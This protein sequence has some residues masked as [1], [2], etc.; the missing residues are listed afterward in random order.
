MAQVAYALMMLIV[1][2]VVARLRDRSLNSNQH[3]FRYFKRYALHQPAGLTMACTFACALLAFILLNPGWEMTYNAEPLNLRFQLPRLALIVLAA[4]ALVSSNLLC[5]FILSLGD[6]YELAN[7]DK[8]RSER[9]KAELITGVSH[10]LRTPLTALISYIGLI[11]TLPIDN[12]DF[13]RYTGIL[14]SKAARLKVLTD[15]LLEASKAATGN[16]PVDKIEI[17]LAEIVG[18]ISGEFDDQFTERSLSLVFEQPGYPVAVSAD[19]RHLWRVL[20]NLFGNIARYAMPQTRVFA[21]IFTDENQVVLSLKNTSEQP[22]DLPV[23]ALTEQFIRG[24]S[25][26]QSEGS[27]LGLYIAKCLIELMDGVFSIRVIGDLFVA[28]MVF[29]R[30]T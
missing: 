5:R 20:E 28:E 26:R 18:Q 7:Q 6:E 25:A 1:G 15:D 24:D 21:D 30:Q 17:D 22:I 10:D 8:I 9:F 12:E 13:D 19:S 29:D 11:K 23:N 14:D 4:M 3:W 27:G 16:L 2:E